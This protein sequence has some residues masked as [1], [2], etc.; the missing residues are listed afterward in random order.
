MGYF[1]IHPCT[2][3]D[4]ASIARNNMSAY[5][6]DPNWAMIWDIPLD[7]LIEDAGRR[8]GHN[9]LKDRHIQRHQKAV[10]PETGELVGYSRW[11][12]PHSHQDAWPEAR[13]AEVTPS[14]A[15]KL[16]QMWSSA[17]SQPNSKYD[18]LDIPIYARMHELKA[19]N[20]YMGGSPGRISRRG[21]WY[22]C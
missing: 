4:A 8:Y 18:V 2:V 17:K 12:M 15:K 13:V 19:G 7:T 1:E 21:G 5:W 10:D 14:E 3:D 11:I 22:L 16:A 9:L 6:T 20:N